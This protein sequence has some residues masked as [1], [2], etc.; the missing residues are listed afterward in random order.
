MIKKLSSQYAQGFMLPLAIFLLVVLAALGAYAMRLSIL[1]NA[2]ST[3]DILS[4]RAYFAARAGAE[5]AAMRV[6]NPGSTSMQNCPADVMPI[7]INNY[8]V[9]IACVK[10][11]YNEQGNDQSVSVYEITSL[12]SQGS[13]GGTDYVERQI[14][15][16]ISRCLDALGN[17]CSG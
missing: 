15:I 9:T 16:T 6:M 4:S 12:A 3:Q 5:W 14:N 17:V 1:T 7:I 8:N 2:G 10:R 11:D 13:V